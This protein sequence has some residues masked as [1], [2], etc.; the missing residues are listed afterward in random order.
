MKYVFFGSPRFAAIILGSLIEADMSP[1]AIVCNPDRPVGRKQIITPPLT[2]QEI[3]ETAERSGVSSAITILQPEK[4]D[5]QFIEHLRALVPDFF[6]VAAYAKIIPQAVLDIPRLG[7]LGTHPSL[8]PKYR[9]ASPIQSALLAGDAITGTTLYAMDAKM[10]H[11]GIYAQREWPIAPGT[12]YLALETQLAALSADALIKLIL[13]FYAGKLTPQEQDES[14]A[15]FTKKFVTQD[16]FVDEKD[17]EDATKEDDD[18]NTGGDKKV[19][20][21]ILNKINALNPEPGCWTI[22]NGKR[23]KL[24]EAEI[25]PSGSLKLTVVQ[26]EGQKPKRI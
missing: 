15:T 4:L 22:Q 11:G 14:R 19:V 8:L 25:E 21:M 10:D 20:R 26:E 24:L 23:I 1:V 12:N 5:E 3:F 2:K 18:A 17:L 7:T 9:G 6:I 16:G 13:N